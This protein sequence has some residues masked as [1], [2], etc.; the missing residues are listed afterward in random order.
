MNLIRHSHSA[1]T[2]FCLLLS[3]HLSAQT[4]IGAASRA[5]NGISSIQAPGFT[6]IFNSPASGRWDSTNVVVADYR[7]MF[8]VQG[9]GSA[10]LGISTGLKSLRLGALWNRTGSDF[11]SRQEFRVHCS[12]RISELLSLGLGLQ[13]RFVRMSGLYRSAGTPIVQLGMALKAGRK[14]DL[15]I[16]WYNAVPVSA[17][18]NDITSAGVAHL[19]AGV[20]HRVSPQAG[21]LAEVHTRYGDYPN[22]SYIRGG[23]W[24]QTGHITFLAGAGNGPEPLSFGIC[25][26]SRQ[27]RLDLA[28]S[29]HA[30][31][32]FSPQCSVNWFW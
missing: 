25:F 5:L 1:L 21:L 10:A 27:F 11:V 22:L 17:N 24:Y 23:I 26:K 7:N 8:G 32:G 13:Y 2:S 16:D 9:L 3:G 18:K 15:V 31:L 29:Y 6:G 12:G 14:T 28:S 4:I 20:R 30:S 19:R